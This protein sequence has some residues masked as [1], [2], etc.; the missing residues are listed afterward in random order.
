MPLGGIEVTTEFL[1]TVFGL[2]SLGVVVAALSPWLTWRR[3]KRADRHRRGAG[4]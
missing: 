4:P 3:L 1:L 2:A